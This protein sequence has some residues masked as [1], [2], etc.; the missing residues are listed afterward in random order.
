MERIHQS[1]MLAAEV[2]NRLGAKLHSFLCDGL[3]LVVP[4]PV[5]V[6]VVLHGRDRKNTES[7]REQQGIYRQISKCVEEVKFAF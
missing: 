5:H 3:E 7:V 6:Q 2:G 1:R 4:P